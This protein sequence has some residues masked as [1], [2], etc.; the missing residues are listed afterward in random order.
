MLLSQDGIRYLLTD[1]R[2]KFLLMMIVYTL[3]PF[4][5]IPEALLGP[6]GLLDDSLVFANII[7]QVSGIIINFVGQEA[8]RNS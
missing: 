6:I 7:R 8:G 3:S 4:D 5:L 1:P 2:I